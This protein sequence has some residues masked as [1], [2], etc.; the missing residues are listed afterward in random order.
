METIRWTV[1]PRLW[2]REEETEAQA[3]AAALLP[4]EAAD[5]ALAFHRQLPGYRPTPLVCLRQLASRIGIGGLWIKDESERLN[6]HSFKAL[7]ASYAVYRTLL[8]RLDADPAELPPSELFSMPISRR[9]PGL[10]LATATDGNHGHALAW[11]ANLIGI[12][13]VVY[14]P[15]LTVD[16]RI[17]AMC[18]FGAKVERI[19]GTY[20]ETVDLLRADAQRHDWQVVSDTGWDGYETV[21]IWVIQGYSTLFSEAQ[22]QLESLGVEKPTHIFIQAG[23]GSLAAAMVAFYIQRFAPHAPTSV[24]VEPT[25]APALFE[26]IGQEDGLP[27]RCAGSLDTIMAGLSCGKPNPVAWPVL[28]DGVPFF[29]LCPDFVAALGMRVYATPLR[30]DPLVISGESGAVTLGALMYLAQQREATVLRNILGLKQDSQV[31]LI[32]SEG[33]THPE[34][35]RNV[36]WQGA[37]AVPETHSIKEEAAEIGHGL[38]T[39]ANVVY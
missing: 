20:D 8:S 15:K 12:P 18:Q 27:H 33:N 24:I 7:G 9:L 3:A 6:L 35:Y 17:A 16:A 14:V 19:D 5:Q 21:P 23:V 10:T 25:R 31:L 38:V 2:L 36:V 29:L 39:P 4:Q 26:S 32:N 1:N 37:Y 34:G 30:G 13:A 22:Q 28:R 11:M